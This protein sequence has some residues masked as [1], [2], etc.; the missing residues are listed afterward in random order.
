MWVVTL[1]L[2]HVIQHGS[3]NIYVLKLISLWCIHFSPFSVHYHCPRTM[4][5]PT[6]WLTSALASSPPTLYLAYSHNSAMQMA[7]QWLSIILN[8]FQGIGSLSWLGPSTY[9]AIWLI[10]IL[11]YAVVGR[12]S[13]VP[14]FLSLPGLCFFLLEPSQHTGHQYD[15]FFF[16]FFTPVWLLNVYLNVT[17]SW[18]PSP[19]LPSCLLLTC[20]TIAFILE[21][22]ML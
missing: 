17:F 18:K 12:S 3:C 8:T 10:F 19:T 16:F 6:T 21:V 1:T 20:P 2:P 4:A 14:G 22:I 5:S 13:N 9:L 7:L 11:T 15:F